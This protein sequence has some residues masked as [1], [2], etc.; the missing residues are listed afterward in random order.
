MVPMHD[1]HGIELLSQP[2]LTDISTVI[3][4]CGK[5]MHKGTVQP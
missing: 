2:M 4:L 5:K 3:L 1:K